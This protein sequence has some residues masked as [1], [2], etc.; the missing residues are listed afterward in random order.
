MGYRTE[1]DRI[2]PY[3][4]A[5]ANYNVKVDYVM[6]TAKGRTFDKEPVRA[7]RNNGVPGPG[8]YNLENS[9][10][11]ASGGFSFRSRTYGNTLWVFLVNIH[12]FK[13]LTALALDLKKKLNFW[14]KNQYLT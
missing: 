12:D 5:G 9:S 13:V 7:P 14:C 3:I 11:S 8:A 6:R 10:L 4:P 2:D 1:I